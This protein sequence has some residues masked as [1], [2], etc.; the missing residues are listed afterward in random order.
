M[1]DRD[2]FFKLL[3]ELSDQNVWRTFKTVD[4]Y[5]WIEVLDKVDEHLAAL[6]GDMKLLLTSEEPNS[7]AKEEGI[8]IS[9]KTLLLFTR[10][11]LQN[12][13]S[14]NIYNSVEV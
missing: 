2:A 7:T 10:N 12:G 9:L 1:G 14:R 11:L 13:N 4:L 8:H 5:Y 3:N 6:L